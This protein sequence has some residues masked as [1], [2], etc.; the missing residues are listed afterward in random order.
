MT[1]ENLIAKLRGI[2][3]AAEE[4][5][6]DETADTTEIAPAEETETEA[7]ETAEENEETTEKNSDGT[8]ETE[9]DGPAEDETTAETDGET[10]ADET[11]ES[12]D[13]TAETDGPADEKGAEN[14]AEFK[15]FVEAFGL[16][17]GAVLYHEGLSIEAARDVY[18][19]ALSEEN[20][21]LKEKLKNV[22]AFGDAEGAEFSANET[23]VRSQ[24]PADR[25][26]DQF[27]AGIA[28]FIR[29]HKTEK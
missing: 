16:E 6:V 24:D 1:L 23:D 20:A 29:K 28:A 7:D 9:T 13:G 15:S 8:A 14:R 17:K 22:A 19:K 26:A 11:A 27:G 2:K 18:S 10:A 12:T 21:E 5:A 25:M 4:N 3:P